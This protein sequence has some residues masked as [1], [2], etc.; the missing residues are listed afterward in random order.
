MNGR[1][2]PKLHIGEVYPGCV[3]ILGG[4]GEDGYGPGV[5]V[6][7]HAFPGVG[8]LERELSLE[9]GDEVEEEEEADA[10]EGEEMITE[11]LGRGKVKEEVVAPAGGCA[12]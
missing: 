1:Y 9:E 5:Y 11:G 10:G 4:M 3:G 12:R 6:G 7:D 8:E 2:G